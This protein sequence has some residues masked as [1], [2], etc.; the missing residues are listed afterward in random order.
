ML[1]NW[2]RNGRTCRYTIRE[3]DAKVRLSTSSVY[4][5]NTIFYRVVQKSCY[6]DLRHQMLA[7]DALSFESTCYSNSDVIKRYPYHGPHERDV[8][9]VR[10][11]LPHKSDLDARTSGISICCCCRFLRRSGH[12]IE[13]TRFNLLNQPL[14]P[15]PFQSFDAISFE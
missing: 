3:R 9:H 1:A 7:G 10:F 14:H 2:S 6:Q 15:G 8:C 11:Q 13:C 12:L 5:H 4:L